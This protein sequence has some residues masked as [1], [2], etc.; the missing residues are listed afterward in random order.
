MIAIATFALGA[1]LAVGAASDQITAGDLALGA[2]EWSAV[3][4]E[5]P[6]GLAPAPG[7]QRIFRLPEL[8]R[9]AQRWNLTPVPDR[10]LCVTRPVAVADP[11][12]LL[13]A[14]RGQLPAATI[15]ILEF[16]HQPAPQ[17]DL[18]FPI[19]GLRQSSSGAIWTGYVKYAGHQRFALWARVKVLVP[20]A[21][22]VAT[23]DFKAGRVLEAA[24]LRIEARQEFPSSGYAASLEEVAGK[25]TRRSIAAGTPLRA[26]WLEASK[27]VTR[28]D[29][30]QIEIVYGA[31][32]LKLEGVAVSSGA[33]GDSVLVLNPDSKRQFRAR[34]QS[35]GKVLVSR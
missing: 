28:G 18:E 29:T 10:E 1:C 9:L 35:P 30:V 20:A 27:A 23:E 7:V 22:V 32:H 2:A 12:L 34:V 24:V 4:A 14:M 21:R 26:E 6:L 5:T 25:V 17:G 8:R 15:E 19:A 11:A 33:V 3:P 16:S 13:A 31:A